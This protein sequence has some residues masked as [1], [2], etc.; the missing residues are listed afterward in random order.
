MKNT[1][2]MIPRDKEERQGTWKLFR[3]RTVGN[4]N[5]SVSHLNLVLNKDKHLYIENKTQC[6][7]KQLKRIC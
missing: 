3:Y 4:C 6:L 5:E 7:K 1:E 2:I